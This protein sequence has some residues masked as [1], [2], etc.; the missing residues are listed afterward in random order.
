MHL[1]PVTSVEQRIIAPY[2]V[3]IRFLLQSTTVLSRS[4]ELMLITFNL[5]FQTMHIIDVNRKKGQTIKSFIITV[6]KLGF[7]CNNSATSSPKLI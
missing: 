2:K 3:T 5:L 7:L 6:L 1:K 4:S